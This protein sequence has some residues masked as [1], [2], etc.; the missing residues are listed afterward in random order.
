MWGL[1]KN[2]YELL[3]EIA[4]KIKDGDYG[5]DND[6]KSY[7]IIEDLEDIINDIGED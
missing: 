2:A 1:Q 7:Y 3:I 6:I 4:K 5:I